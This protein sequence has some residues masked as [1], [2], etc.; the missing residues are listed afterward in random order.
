MADAYRTLGKLLG[1][2]DKA[3]ELAQYEKRQKATHEIAEKMMP[4]G[5]HVYCLG[6]NGLNVIAEGSFHAKSQLL[7]K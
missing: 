7:S 5:S 6:D 1:V 2:D 3:E 4:K